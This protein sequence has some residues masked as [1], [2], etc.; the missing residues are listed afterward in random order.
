MT[1]ILT[2][3]FDEALIFSAHVHSGQLRKG[4]TIPYIAHL[5]SVDSLVITHG[6]VEDEAIAAL[7]HDVGEDQE[8]SPLLPSSEH[9]LV[10]LSLISLT[11]AP[12]PMR[13]K[14]QYGATAERR[15]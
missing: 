13:R 8:E 14:S 12:T 6:G 2:G 3:R 1:T 15:I 4:T 5:L 9:V 7:L 10:T 11:V